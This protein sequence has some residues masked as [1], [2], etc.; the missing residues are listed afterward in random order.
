MEVVLVISTSTFRIL[1]MRD[2]LDEFFFIFIIYLF[3]YLLFY[4]LIC[5]IIWN[6]PGL[7]SEQ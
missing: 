4:Y 6:G 7:E 1:T 5:S 2:E 3:I